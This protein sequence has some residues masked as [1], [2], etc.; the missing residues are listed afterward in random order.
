MARRVGRRGAREFGMISREVLPDR[1]RRGRPIL[2]FTAHVM[3]VA[4]RLVVPR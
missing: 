2:T 1:H 3:A 4:V